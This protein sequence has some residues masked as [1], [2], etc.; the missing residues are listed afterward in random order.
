MRHESVLVMSIEEVKDHLLN[1]QADMIVSDRANVLDHLRHGAISE[2]CPDLSKMD[3][4]EMAELYGE[5]NLGEKFAKEWYHNRKAVD[6]VLVEDGD[7]YIVVWDY[8]NLSPE[9]KDN[10]DKEDACPWRHGDQYL[11]REAVDI[12]F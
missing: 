5:L 7:K 10:F 4:E 1:W 12:P 3:N 11:K 6:Q 9:D 8:D 2:I